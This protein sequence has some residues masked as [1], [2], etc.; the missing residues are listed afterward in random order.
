M[1]TINVILEGEN[2]KAIQVTRSNLGEVEWFTNGE[3]KCQTESFT[4]SGQCEIWCYKGQGTFWLIEGGYILKNK[5]SVLMIMT[6]YEFNSLPSLPS[7]Q[8]PKKVSIWERILNLF[9]FRR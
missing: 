7:L 6:E 8:S 2:Y 3:I 1:K 5:K 4:Q 9:N